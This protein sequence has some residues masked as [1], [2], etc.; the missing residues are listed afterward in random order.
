MRTRL[1]T[2]ALA[3]ITINAFSQI[4]VTDADLISVGDVVYEASDDNPSTVINIGNAGAV[5][6]NWDFSSLQIMDIEEIEVI[7][8]I[9]TPFAG[10]YPNADMCVEMDDELLYLDKSSSGIQVVGFGGIP[11]NMLLIPLPLTYG[12][13]YQDGPNTI[14]DSVL[15]NSFIDDSLA[16]YISLNPSYDQIDSLKITVVM[17]SDF[18]VDAW[19]GITIP[20]GTY[21]SLRVKVEETTIS[22]NSLYCSSSAG[23]GGGWYVLPAETELAIRYEWWT[24]DTSVKLRLIEL[25]M[26]SFNNVEAAI[27]LTQPPVTSVDNSS[28]IS[29]KV[30]PNPTSDKLIV[31]TMLNNCSYNLLDISGREIISCNFNNSA[32]IDLTGYS[33]GAYFLRISNN[34]N[35]I[36]KKIVLE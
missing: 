5:S 18:T 16:P 10:M 20:M 7:S 3:F 35:V 14:M 15:V 22:N 23:L 13:N 4:T 24:N 31:N 6:Q 19:G 28:E 9:G 33:V 21:A 12:L 34:D 36:T 32:V 25:E 11:G 17:T 27:F 30:Y 2:I 26:D 29:V 8:P 1:F